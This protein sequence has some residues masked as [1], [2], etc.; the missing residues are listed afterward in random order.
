MAVELAELVGQ[1]R[2]ELTIAMQVG[3]DADL[4]FELGPVEL[5]LTVAV[6]KEAKAGAKVRFWV[7]EAGADGKVGSSS[8][9]KIKLKLDPRV[10]SQPGRQPLISGDEDS[11]E[12]DD[13]D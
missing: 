5:E 9:Q 8:T 13:E 10:A 4:R 1:L 2:A 6:D 3:E 7:V 12:R 11:G